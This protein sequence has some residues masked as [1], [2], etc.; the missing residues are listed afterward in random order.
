[1]S[2]PAVDATGVGPGFSGSPIYC[3]DGAG[4]AA[5][6]GAISRV[7]RRVRRQDRARDADRGDPRHAG[8]RAAAARPRPIGARRA[9]R[10]RRRARPLAAPLT[11]SG[12]SARW[13]DALT[14]P[15]RR[16]GGR[17]WPCRRGPLGPVPAADAAPGLGGR[18]GYSSGDVR[19]ERGRHRRLRRRRPRVGLR[20][21]ARGR[22]PARAAAAGRLRLPDHQQPVSSARIGSTYKLAAVRPRPRHGH[23]RRRSAPS[24]AAPARPPHTVP[25]Q[26][27][28]ADEDSGAHS[29]VDADAADEADVD[30][31]SGGSWT[32]FVAPLAVAQ[33][34]GGV[35]GSTPGRLTRRRCA[36][37][38]RSRELKRPLRFCNRYVSA[39]A[40]QG[41][42]GGA[43]NAVLERRRQRPRRRAPTIDAYTGKPPQRDRRRR[44]AEAPPRRRPGVHPR[45]RAAARASGRA[46]GC[47][48]GSPSSACAAPRSRAPTRCGS[49]RDARAGTPD[50]CAS[51]A[52]TPTRATTPSRRSSSATRK[53][54]NEGGDPGPAS[55]RELADAGRRDRALRRRQRAHRP[56]PRR[57]VPRRRLPRL[58]PGRDDRPRRL[59]RSSAASLAE[60][61]VARLVRARSG[62]RCPA[63]R[64]AA[65][66]SGSAARSTRGER[67]GR[68]GH[69]LDQGLDRRR[70][71]LDA[72]G[73][74]G[75]GSRA[76]RTGARPRRTARSP[77]RRSATPR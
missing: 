42:D 17:C 22:R 30:M 34:A 77:G 75:R 39:A 35:L 74:V 16:R 71:V 50:A 43:S 57:G 13:R 73:V 33:A 48:R 32:S 37:G 62:R 1:M 10:D 25:V 8:R 66:A 72:V 12:L 21:P 24:P 63:A 65:A 60:P 51:S 11:V 27:D 29:T 76:A 45:R 64:R 54:E 7:G 38:S 19:D 9:A 14:R 68:R 67:L 23:Q 26:R 69:H 2:G 18:V 56:R 40:G 52:R 53:S 28:R 59:A 58:R 70:L 47:A 15:A 44:A 36:R 5:T 41:D 46:S 61:G 49:P 20:P 3:P 55:L 6:I 4:G 31:P